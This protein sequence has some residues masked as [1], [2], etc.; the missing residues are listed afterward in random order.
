MDNKNKSII[1]A[2]LFASG[3]PVSVQKMAKFLK[4][5]SKDCEQA[6]ENLS[7]DYEDRSA[8]LQIIRNGN[9]IQLASNGEYGKFVVQFLKKNLNEPLSSAAMEVLSVI[10]YRGPVTRAQIE[11]IRGVNCSFTLRNLAIRG[12]VTR[13]ENPAD[14]RAYLYET[15]NEFIKSLGLND[16]AGFPDYELLHSSE[17]DEKPAKKIKKLSK[18]EQQ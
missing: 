9:T 4:I 5:S 16:V 10:A 17:I 1:E 7:R 14:N 15:S 8:G 2:L 6:I 18:N 11:Y 12:L 3:E 13:R